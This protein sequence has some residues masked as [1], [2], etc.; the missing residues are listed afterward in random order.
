MPDQR[1]RVRQA[2]SSVTFAKNRLDRI[3]LFAPEIRLDPA[4]LQALPQHGTL[5]ALRE[6]V[7]KL[8]VFDLIA[9]QNR[10]DHAGIALCQ[11]IA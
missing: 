3:E 6:G 11:D 2:V 4:V 1:D 7:I 5:G 8:K 10:L 9:A